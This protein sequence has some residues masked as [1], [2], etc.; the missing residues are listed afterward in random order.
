MTSAPVHNIPVFTIASTGK[1][2][3]PTQV[4]HR[5]TAAKIASVVNFHNDVSVRV[6]Q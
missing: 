4:G 6:G 2:R 5:D 3:H 1:P